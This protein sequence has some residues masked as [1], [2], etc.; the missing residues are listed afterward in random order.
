MP[1]CISPSLKWYF[2]SSENTCSSPYISLHKVHIASVVILHL[3]RLPGDG[4]VSH[5]EA[6][7][8]R[9]KVSWHCHQR[10]PWKVLLNIVYPSCPLNLQLESFWEGIGV[11]NWFVVFCWNISLVM[12]WRFVS[13]DLW[14]GGLSKPM[15]VMMAVSTDFDWQIDFN[16]IITRQNS[17]FNLPNASLEF[18]D[19]AWN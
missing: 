16:V 19:A 14:C 6:R 11:I 15:P 4:S 10:G 9:S 7:K 13:R 17:I 18:R 2:G 1:E 5:V 12:F 3:L 8:K